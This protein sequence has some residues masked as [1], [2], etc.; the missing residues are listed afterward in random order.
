VGAGLARILR[1][2]HDVVVVDIDE[3]RC[4]EVYAELG[5]LTVHG[6]ATHFGALQEAG[7]ARARVTLALMRDDADNM[8]PIPT[9]ANT[10]TGSSSP[11]PSCCNDNAKVAPTPAPKNSVGVNTP[12]TAPQPTVAKVA[13]SLAMNNP[14][15]NSS[16]VA[17]VVSPRPAPNSRRWRPR[18]RL[19][20]RR[21]TWPGPPA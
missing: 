18:T 3:A 7:I 17:G 4:A 15:R 13:A 6:S 1:D 5:V 8:L 21:D 12:P 20:Q 2:N 10:A 19:H 16:A 11:P 14:T 9:T